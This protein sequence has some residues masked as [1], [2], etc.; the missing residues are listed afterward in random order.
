[1]DTQSPTYSD[2]EL[3]ASLAEHLASLDRDDSY[4]VERVLKCSDVETTE[5][6]YFEGSGGG[7]LGPFVRKRIDASAQI[8]GPTSACLRLSGPDA[9]LNTYP[10]LSIAAARA[11]SS[12]W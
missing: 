1:M 4:R 12:M 10:G 2:D 5:L 9:V 8:G 7:S 6:V 3:T 11:R